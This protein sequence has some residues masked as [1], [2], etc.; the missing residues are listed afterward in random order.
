MSQFSLNDLL[1]RLGKT[2]KGV[3][4]GVTLLAMAGASA[5]GISQSMYT[6]EA[7][8]L[9]QW[10]QFIIISKCLWGVIFLVSK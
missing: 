5:Y 6:G 8:I 10:Q 9:D 4:T 1:S 7:E 3:N 2:P